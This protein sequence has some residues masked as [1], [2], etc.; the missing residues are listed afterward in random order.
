MA[1][2]AFAVRT[3]GELCGSG[4]RTSN[5]LHPTPVA[6]NIQRGPLLSTPPPNH[7]NSNPIQEVLAILQAAKEEVKEMLAR[8]QKEKGPELKA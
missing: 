7:P 1:L 5:S 8:F 2:T 4:E 6:P 3:E